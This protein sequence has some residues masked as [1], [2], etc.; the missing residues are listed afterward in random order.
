MSATLH[1]IQR[2]S[3]IVHIGVPH[4]TGTAQGVPINMSIKGT[5]KM[6]MPDSQLY[7]YCRK[8]FELTG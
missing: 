1:E 4:R 6:V 2:S 7:P 8:T 3:S 5:V